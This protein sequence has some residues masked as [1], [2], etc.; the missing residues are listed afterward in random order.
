MQLAPRESLPFDQGL[1]IYNWFFPNEGRDPSE[2]LP[3]A[4]RATPLDALAW[5]TRERP[6]LRALYV[7]VPFC[8]TICSFCPF[9]RTV[10]TD[11]NHLDRYVDAL[12]LELAMKASLPSIAE[13]PI[14]AI[15]IGGGTPSILNPAQIRRLGRALHSHLDLS[16]LVEFSYEMNVTTVDPDRLEAAKEIG[17]THPRTGVQTFS[18]R[19][20]E[21]FT[22]AAT[23]DD[24]YSAVEL[25]VDNFENV[26]VDILYGM[27][28]QTMDELIVDAQC[29]VDLGTKLVDLYPLNNVVTQKRLHKSFAEEGLQATSVLTKHAMNMALDSFMRSSGFLPHN[30]HG[31][32]R[33]T[34]AKPNDG[35]IV[36]D[37]YTFEYHEAVYGYA[38][39]EIVGIGA[40]AVSVLRELTMR[41][42]PSQAEYMRRVLDDR[43]IPA[44]FE[45]HDPALDDSKGIVLHLPYHGHAEKALLDMDKIHP[46]TL[47]TLEELKAAGLVEETP[48][49][50]ELTKRGWHWYVNLLYYLAPRSEQS[51][52]DQLIN[53]TLAA[54]DWRDIGELAINVPRNGHDVM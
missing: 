32:V 25:M 3:A 5:A 52:L 51:V 33:T 53:Q 43:E 54:E 48:S 18:S 13:H 1:P 10:N 39:H 38:R 31:Y 35:V 17:V 6:R 11:T 46:E 16:R 42:V 41:N 45:A 49:R 47:Q 23:L 15:F 26:C 20:R 8:E 19:Y 30:G 21:H 9:A 14:H 34:K 27:H 28:G 50:Y 4:A 29:A 2:E 24:V 44:S 7:H 36:S 22:L 40:A 37:E 12:E